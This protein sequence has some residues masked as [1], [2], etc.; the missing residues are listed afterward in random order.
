MLLVLFADARGPIEQTAPFGQRRPIRDGVALTAPRQ[1][2][3]FR[4]GAA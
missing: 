4:C 2:P 1:M 3:R